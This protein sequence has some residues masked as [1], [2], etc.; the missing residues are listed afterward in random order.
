MEVGW[1]TVSKVNF[2]IRD[3]DGE[4]FLND[5]ISNW[6]TDLSVQFFS[7]IMAENVHFFCGFD[8]SSVYAVLHV[9][10]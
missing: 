6:Y 1:R 5:K 7:L 4:N 9:C 10:N 3:E 2:D 8:L